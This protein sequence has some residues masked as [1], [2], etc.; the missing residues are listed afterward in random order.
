M[1][2]REW[3]EGSAAGVC[4][5]VYLYLGMKRT[6]DGIPSFKSTIYMNLKCDMCFWIQCFS[7]KL[8]KKIYDPYFLATAGS[9]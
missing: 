9:E 3:E 2:I 5:H 1:R 8:K 4:V 6:A 7:L